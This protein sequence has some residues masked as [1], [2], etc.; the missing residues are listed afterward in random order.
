VT[1]VSATWHA[2]YRSQRYVGKAAVHSFHLRCWE[3]ARKCSGNLEFRT[4]LNRGGDKQC[5]SQWPRSLG[6][7]PLVEPF[8]GLRVRKKSHRGH[9][10]CLLWMSVCCQV[11]VC[12]T[13]W[14]LVQRSPAKCG[15]SE[16]DIGTSKR[17]WPR[18]DFGC[19]ATRKKVINNTSLSIFVQLVTFRDCDWCFVKSLK[20]F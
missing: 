1:V 10:F 11:E 19:W 6:R 20:H 5:R 9:G 7:G 2:A 3:N 14:S 12:V 16:C 8:L 4:G 13:D 18:L 15:E 17:R